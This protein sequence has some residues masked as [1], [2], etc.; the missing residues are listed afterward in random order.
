MSAAAAFVCAA[1]DR[2]AEVGVCEFGECE[3]LGVCGET[4]PDDT[5]SS[6]M[7]GVALGVACGVASGVLS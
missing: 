5:Q 7:V 6:G 2:L 1:A 3:A 4:Q